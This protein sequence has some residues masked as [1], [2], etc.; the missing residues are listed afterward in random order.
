M[1]NLESGKLD[2]KTEMHPKYFAQQ[3][4]PLSPE[5]TLTS[6]IRVYQD[7]EQ[8][9]FQAASFRSRIEGLLPERLRS[10]YETQ[11]KLKSYGQY[12]QMPAPL[13]P[14]NDESRRPDWRP[15]PPT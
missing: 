10:Q 3:V 4:D 8:N 9:R 6:G 14:S 1:Q 13:E 12:P 15:E 5:A 7:P 11:Q 2:E